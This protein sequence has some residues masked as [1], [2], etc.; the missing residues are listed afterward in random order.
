MPPSASDSLQR[1]RQ[2]T[3]FFLLIALL[4]LVAAA[5][6]VLCDTLDPD[7]FWHLR[8][9]RQLQA[10]G[11]RPLID[12]LSFAST[13][14]PWT[15]Y[16][17]LAEL[18][19]AWIWGHLGWRGAVAVQ[20]VLQAAF[21]LIIGLTCS[22]RATNA[23]TGRRNSG[24]EPSTRLRAAAAT[25]FA[26]ILS[27][28]Y[29]SFRPVTAALV[30]LALCM[31]LLVRD[32][33]FGER[34]KA[35]W[36]LLPITALTVNL[37]LYAA[38]VPIWVIALLVGALWELHTVQCPGDRPEAERRAV[39]YSWL[40]AGCIAAC[41]ATPM[42]PGMIRVAIHYQ[43]DDAM[44]GGPV[45]AEMQPFYRGP[46]G[47]AAVA[48]VALCL[49]CVLWHRR[50]L[51]AGE[52]LLLL[53]GGALLMRMGRFS[54]VFAI[55]AA[56]CL[57][58][59]LP[60]LSDRLLGRPPIWALLAAV[61]FM[62]GSRVVVSFPWSDRP[63]QAWLNRLGPQAP[64]YPC[65]AADYV[66]SHV[67]PTTGHL[68]NEFSWGGYLEWRLGDRYRTFL[69]GRTQLFPQ[70]FWQA[71]YL[72]TASERTRFLADVPADA[73]ILPIQRSTFH[74]S[75]AKLG[76]TTAYSDDR[77]EVMLPPPNTFTNKEVPWSSAALFLDE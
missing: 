48:A 39:R 14:S 66:A 35:V 38:L 42:L 19:M 60:R 62:A 55:V 52:A 73:A 5:K 6:A 74:D 72:G 12:H 68:I 21:V 46:A 15:P 27:L 63:L 3:G 50:R 54:P 49:F 13:Q 9:A 36:L 32:R 8:V 71:T 41:L 57:A 22:I 40:L 76:W 33:S 10:E 69:D 53:I 77:A 44:I 11:V 47:N 25:A 31:G 16:S 37:H 26:L 43:F 45:I 29:L 7:C 2:R 4:A 58:A 51:R 28:A 34:T 64:G 20:A 24:L 18:G 70:S 61:L 23:I 75:L 30:L 1:K 17:W 59:T 56:P 65:A 67:R